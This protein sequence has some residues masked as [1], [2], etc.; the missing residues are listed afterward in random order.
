MA[1]SP[2]LAR[3]TGWEIVGPNWNFFRRREVP[4]FA[5]FDV[6]VDTFSAKNT[7][8]NNVDDGSVMGIL[9]GVVG[10][11]GGKWYSMLFT[12]KFRRNLDDKQRVAIPKRLRSLF[13]SGSVDA[14]FV[15]PGTDGSLAIYTEE[16]FIQLANRLRM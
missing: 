6:L 4:L 12:G 7:V 5:V 10:S 9:R 3:T 14:C 13:E 15:A 11:N 8:K 16:S 2:N 1:A